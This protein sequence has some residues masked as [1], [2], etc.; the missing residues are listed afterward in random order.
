MG[1]KALAAGVAIGLA[2]L[3]GGIGMGLAIAKSADGI[4]RQPE[5]EGK[6]RS[7]LMIGLVFVETVVIYALIV[8]ILVIF[9]L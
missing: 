9:V 5:A 4:S 8:S 7:A 1:S 2:C 3:G 6:I